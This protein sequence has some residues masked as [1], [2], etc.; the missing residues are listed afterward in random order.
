MF[1]QTL[2]TYQHRKPV[3][4]SRSGT[5]E[6]QQR[7]LLLVGNYPIEARR[8]HGFRGTSQGKLLLRTSPQAFA[9][10]SSELQSEVRLDVKNQ[11]LERC[12]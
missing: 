12:H 4:R 7:M 11:A 8:L 5:T 1:Q 2:L 6:L 9:I 10:S 3:L